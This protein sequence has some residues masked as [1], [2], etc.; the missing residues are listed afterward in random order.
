MRHQAFFIMLPLACQRKELRALRQ[1]LMPTAS[2]AIF[3]LV[4]PL[5]P[6]LRDGTIPLRQGVVAQPSGE[7]ADAN[8]SSDRV[9]RH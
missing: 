7:E 4:L 2:T 1:P 9:L 8:G 3:T 6:E 5:L